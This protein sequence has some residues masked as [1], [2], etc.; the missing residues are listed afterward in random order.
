MQTSSGYYSSCQTVHSARRKLRI[1]HNVSYALNRK[2][3]GYVILTDYEG[4]ENKT[5][6]LT[7]NVDKN[8]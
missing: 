2:G 5:T 8:L 7:S 3:L 6:T 1:S 4:E